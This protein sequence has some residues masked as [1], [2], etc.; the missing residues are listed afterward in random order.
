M[1]RKV[2]LVVVSVIWMT[3]GT[4]T[5]GQ[6]A[7]A[8]AGPPD[9]GNPLRAILEALKQGAQTDSQ[10]LIQL[11][12]LQGRLEK[13]ESRLRPAPSAHRVWVAPYWHD[14]VTNTAHEG[15]ANIC[16]RG[17]VVALNPGGVDADVRV[18]FVT[19]F[20]VVRRYYIAR[21]P[22]FAGDNTPLLNIPLEPFPCSKNTGWVIVASDRPVLPYGWFTM[23]WALDNEHRPEILMQF[24]PIDCTN[25]DDDTVSFAC[26][27]ADPAND[28]S[29]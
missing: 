14:T 6:I 13:L 7:I 17:K 27:Y 24:Y 15:D 18:L 12:N 8:Q 10:I 4:L 21:Y 19:H 16:W 28:P 25:P 9:D 20:V 1:T 23:G 5:S 26:F 11:Q 29:Q 22:A 2:A 3:F